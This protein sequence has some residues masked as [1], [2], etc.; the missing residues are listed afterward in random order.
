MHPSPARFARLVTQLK[1]RLLEGGGQAFYELGVADEGAL[2][3][4]TPTDLADT[5]DTFYAMAK[6]IGA[7][8]VIV[9]EIEVTGNGAREGRNAKEFVRKGGRDRERKE[10]KEKDRR[11]KIEKSRKTSAEDAAPITPSSFNSTISFATTIDS[12]PDVPDLTRLSATPSP[13]TVALSTPADP[14]LESVPA[15]KVDLDD[16]LALFSM[17]PE[18]D[19]LE[20]DDAFY[21]PPTTRPLVTPTTTQRFTIDLESTSVVAC[22]TYSSTTPTL[23]EV[24]S[25]SPAFSSPFSTLTS[26][27]ISTTRAPALSPMSKA[28]KRRVAR[29]LRRE[30]RRRALEDPVIDSDPVG[31]ASTS[32]GIQAAEADGVVAV[33]EGA[34]LAADIDVSKATGDEL[35]EMLGRVKLEAGG[36][37]EV[38]IPAQSDVAPRLIVEAMVVRELDFD[39]TFLDFTM[40]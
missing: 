37:V 34:V 15:I 5:L 4:L 20:R 13:P 16:S 12:D 10:C 19:L 14:G 1:W 2:V 6:E 24:V 38:T 26:S 39:E 7:K 11:A 40:V 33:A 8:V 31:H 3:G 25:H 18:P 35:A 23:N 30:L 22:T 29:D 32:L 17:D 27:L 9:K 28:Q 36:K 21:L